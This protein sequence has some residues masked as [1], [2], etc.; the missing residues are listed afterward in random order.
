MQLDTVTLKRNVSQ[1]LRNRSNVGNTY[2]NPTK[3]MRLTPIFFQIVH[4]TVM[5]KRHVRH[6]KR[7]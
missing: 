2:N 1:V 7:R 4:D 3:K 6:L 5:L